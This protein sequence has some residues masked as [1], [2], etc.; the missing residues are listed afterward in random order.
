MRLAHHKPAERE[1]GQQIKW[2]MSAKKTNS[3]KQVLFAQQHYWMNLD[4][5]TQRS[6]HELDWYWLQQVPIWSLLGEM[7][8]KCIWEQF[9]AGCVSTSIKS[10]SVES[11]FSNSSNTCWRET[12]VDLSAKISL[13]CPFRDTSERLSDT[14]VQTQD[15]TSWQHS[16]VQWTCVISP[17]LDLHMETPCSYS[18][19]PG[20]T[21][22]Q[23]FSAQSTAH[24]NKPTK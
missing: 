9:Q 16:E 15:V 10:S 12:R 14:R 7:G 11:F 4:D 2:H 22:A 13:R 24:R 19:T 1:R 20:S 3:L 5:H 6:H 17:H 21:H 8:H 18:V 23:A